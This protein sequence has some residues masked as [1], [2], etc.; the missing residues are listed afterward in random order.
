MVPMRNWLKSIRYTAQQ[1]KGYCENIHNDVFTVL[2]I[3]F[4]GAISF[5]LGRLSA[6][7][8]VVTP[9]TL[10]Q[11]PAADIEPMYLGGEVVASRRGTKYHFPWCSGATSMN[12]VNK[13]WFKTVEDARKAGYTPA[14]NCKGLR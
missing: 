5:G 9:V 6:T 3:V 11:A 4:V 10:L 14:S 12:E 2:L 8:D 1:I 13:I 7:E